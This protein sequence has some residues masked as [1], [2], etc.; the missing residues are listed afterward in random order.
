MS[1]TMT[2]GQNDWQQI[3]N[4]LGQQVDTNNTAIQLMNAISL[5]NGVLGE[6]EIRYTQ[7]QN[8]KRVFVSFVGMVIPN[9]LMNQFGALIGQLPDGFTPRN[10][11]QFSL[12]SGVHAHL[13][14]DGSI[15]LVNTG[16]LDSGNTTA[17]MVGQ[18]SYY[19][20]N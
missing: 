13:Y 16:S 10:E 18:V 9:T 7:L 4:E 1:E 20:A 12:R 17:E 6:T 8:C 2:K 5:T 15:K 19:T 11:A 14:K 3:V